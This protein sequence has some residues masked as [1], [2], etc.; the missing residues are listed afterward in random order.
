[1]TADLLL[2]LG[3]DQTFSFAIT[4]RAISFGVATFCVSM[5][6]ETFYEGE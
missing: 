1:M 3:Q 6:K 2:G 5:W 4:V